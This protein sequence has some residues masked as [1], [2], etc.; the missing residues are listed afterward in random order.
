MSRQAWFVTFMALCLAV[1]TLTVWGENPT[2]W[3]SELYPEDWTPAFTDH[4]G[5][6][7][8]DFSYAG[9]H[10]GERPLPES[11]PGPRVDVTQAPYY[12]D[13]TGVESVSA[14]IQEAINDVGRAGGG[15]VYLPPGTYR[16]TFSQTYRTEALLV[17][18]SNVVIQGAGPD[19]TFLFLDET[20][21][22]GKAMIRVAPVLTG[23]NWSDIDGQGQLVRTDVAARETV[24]PL[25][26]P[27][28]FAVGEWV[29][30]QYD[31][32]P[33]WVAEHHMSDGWD[34][35]IGGPAFY[36]EIVAVDTTKNTITIDAPLRYTVKVR[37]KAR[38]HRVSQPLTEV[39]L[40][41]FAISMR[42]HPSTTGWGDND[43]GTLGTG[44]YDVHTSSAVSFNGVINSWVRD[45]A[46]YLA[47]GSTYAHIHSV[48]FNF[49]RSRFLTVRRVSVE[50]PQYR[51]GGGNGYPF[52]VGTQDS[53]YDSLRAVNGRHNFTISGQRASGNVI[54][55]G[56]ISNPIQSL[57]ADFHAYL[58]MA[59]LIDNLTI[60][61]DRFEAADRSHAAGVSGFPKHGVTTTQSV[62]WNNEGLSYRPDRPAI[63]RSDQYGWGYVIGTRGPA[64]RVALGFSGRTEPEDYVE[65]EGLGATLQ[66]QSL[67][68]DQLER[69]LL[70]E[71]KADRW[72]AVRESLTPPP[73][74]EWEP[75][76]PEGL[77]RSA[78]PE[79]PLIC[80]EDF[81]SASIDDLP[82]GWDPLRAASSPDM[83]RVVVAPAEL[84]ALHGKVLCLGRTAGTS[85]ATGQ[86]VFDFPPVSERLVVTFDMFTTT[87]RRNLRLTLG[88]S[89][90]PP[91][92]VHGSTANAGLFIAMNGGRVL[93]LLD[94]KANTWAFG[95]DYGAGRWHTVTFDINIREQTFNMYVDD[96][97]LPGNAEPVPFYRSY[98][99]LC[100]LA[101]A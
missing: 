72:E 58:S 19:K 65:G 76:E 43:H 68:V 48:G 97:A 39:G 96:A 20:V 32:T 78:E 86:A 62:F 98:D 9:Y 6:F 71:G 36:R 13:H 23:V 12:A 50:N 45:I 81:E 80:R 90:L 33:E 93:A 2:A 22:R 92:S 89:D 54:Y 94:S 84:G 8:H 10:A 26:G 70:R 75:T 18:Y 52:V 56:Y 83:P 69:R 82:D 35:S 88:G 25:V 28:P 63:I 57:A 37:D 29:V 59:N 53:L 15:T 95:G 4:E 87:E 21:T 30:V 49:S 77:R 44:A 24:I 79:L 85:T 14:A 42:E 61:N 46:T 55:R 67:Y 7:L 41:D 17:A 91:Q 99:D 31:C 101:F 5:R 47:P 1:S 73:I 3:R 100:T 11:V 74:T 16:L 60:D 51:G 40:A 38:V 64:F 66:P 27:P 34:S